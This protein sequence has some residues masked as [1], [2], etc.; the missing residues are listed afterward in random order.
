MDGRALRGEIN[1]ERI[2]SSQGD[3]KVTAR[4]SLVAWSAV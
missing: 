3:I 1:H 4:C 2:I